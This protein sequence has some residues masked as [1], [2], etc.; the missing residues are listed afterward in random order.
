MMPSRFPHPQTATEEGLL[1]VGG[2]YSAEVLVDAYTHGIFPWP[3]EGYPPLWFSPDPRGILDFADL[4][5]SRSLIKW[6]RHHPQWSYTVNHAFSQV[7]RECQQQFRP[8]QHGTW[9]RPEMIPAYEQLFEQGHILSLECW[10]GPAS[11][12]KLIGGIYGVLVM[13]PAGQLVF[14]GESMFHKQSNASKMAFWKMAEHLQK[15]GHQWMDLQM[16][17]EVT[18]AFGGK[19]I[20][21]AEYLRRL[22]V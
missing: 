7:I 6:D 10:E 5:V 12:K 16:I 21:R 3:Q 19:Y 8:N 2:E 1:A 17:T 20:P 18:A 22:G 15:Q 13:S 9:I 4:H 11:A 14:S